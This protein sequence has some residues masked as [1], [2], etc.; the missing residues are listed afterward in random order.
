MWQSCG[1]PGNY[2]ILESSSW[3]VHSNV[4]MLFYALANNACPVIRM[5]SHTSM[6]ALD[7]RRYLLSFYF[8]MLLKKIK[9]F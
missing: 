9:N 7:H 3:G 1:V 4:L 6:Y 5:S 2:Y 8:D